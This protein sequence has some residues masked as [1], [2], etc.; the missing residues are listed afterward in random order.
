MVNAMLALLAALRNLILALA[1]SWVGVTL[2]RTSPHKQ[3]DADPACGRGETVCT[4]LATGFDALECAK[5]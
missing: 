2:E 5:R 1:L 3:P 4:S